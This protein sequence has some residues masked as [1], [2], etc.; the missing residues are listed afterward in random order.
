MFSKFFIERPRFAIVIALV[1][2][3]AGL[4][5]LKNLP[6]EKY[7]TITPPQVMVTATYPGAS[8]DVVE[9]T[10]AS[11]LETAV[12]GVENMIYMSSSSS[13]G[14]YRL[15]IYFQV[16]TDP[17][18]AVV[19]VQNKLSLATARLPDEV[20]RYG[21]TIKQSTQGSG[22][23]MYGLSSPDNSVD[24]LTVSNYAS[25]FIKD[26]LA[27]I[28]GVAEVNVFGARD[29]AIRIWL[30]AQKMASLNVSPSEVN[31]A[32]Q[33]QNAQVP[34]GE[35]G[36]EPMINKQDLKITLRTK[37]RLA[38]PEEFGNIVVKS[39]P[40]G[41]AIRVKDIA[42]VELDAESFSFAGRVNMEPMVVIQVVQL[43]NANAIDI[44]DKAN[45]RMEELSKTFPKGIEYKITRDETEF[46]SESLAEVGKAIV[47]AII[48]V[49]LTVY[50]FLGDWRASLIPFLAIPVSLIGTFNFFAAFGFSLNT[51]TLFGL[52][53]AVGT[54]VDDAIVVVE[55]V[56]RHIDEEGRKPKEATII[57]M[58]EVS[59]A[60]L[61]TSLV[62]MAVFVPV[63]FLSGIQGKMFQQFA[64]TIAVSIG[65]STLV[66]FT[67]AP[68]LCAIILRSK[69]E[70][71]ERTIFE[72]YTAFHHDYWES[73]NATTKRERF[74]ALG[75]YLACI[76]DVT[77]KKFN[78]SFEKLRDKYLMGS[79]YFIKRPSKT[80]WVYL[81]LIVAMLG[82][83]KLTP[84][85]FLPEED[86][87]ALMTNVILTDGSTISKT[88]ELSARIE[89]EVMKLKGVEYV[90]GLVGFSG[91]NTAI[92]ITVFKPWQERAKNIFTKPENDATLQGMQRR[93]GAI[94]AK[95]TD[96]R[97]QSFVPPSIPGL[98]M[99]GGLEYQLLDKGN[100]TPQE[101]G[102]E[103]NKFIS[104][105]QRDPTFANPG[106]FTQYNYNTPQMI[107]NIDYQKALAQGIPVSE[108]YTAL[109]AQF[110]QA[111]VND[112]NRYGRVFRVIMQAEEE[113]RSK[114]G[115]LDKI[116]VK[117]AS[118]KMSPLSSIVELEPITGPYSITRFNMYP[119]VQISALPAQGKSSGDAIKT[120]EEFSKSLPQD[121]GYAWSGTSLQEIEASGQIVV[122][123]GMILV[124]VYLFLVA[125]YESWMLPIGVM[126]I[127]PIAMLGAV[128]L[129]Y[130]T[131]GTVD[132]YV[133]IGFIMLI[134]LAAKQA[135]LIIEFAKIAREEQG[136]SVFEAA[137][138]AAKIRFRAVMMTSLAFILGILPLVFATGPG[139]ESR[140]SLGVTVFGGMVAAAI[141]GAILVPAFYTLVQDLREKYAWGKVKTAKSDKREENE[142]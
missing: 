98:S 51:L 43:A 56:Q 2:V 61:A 130:I 25:I 80:V 58:E 110:G 138:E 16:G 30:D 4:I 141:I 92:L 99:F 23:V 127:A 3:L 24:L 82:L 9:K 118:G 123:L 1:I 74:M 11:I 73:V 59:G 135:I 38:S 104:E 87:G 105:V 53:L 60:V 94:T 128:F 45:K 29:Y 93:I 39:Q 13:N 129:R 34:A 36:S 22:L 133:Q 101:L 134:G 76:W 78:K 32:I 40:N 124:F 47:L 35:I 20:K 8:A 46:I 75:E 31:A 44:A 10:V 83:F 64:V 126:L 132:L 21:L 68:A 62:L 33:A 142:K 103:A 27:R 63:A 12:N 66:A 18:I 139:S 106:V 102:F 37:G 67:L 28:K 49:V 137:M 125:L 65:F 140:R 26:E 48:L 85:G 131:G 109:G 17:N 90:I 41:Q 113:Y 79:E 14:S 121:M 84:Q 136:L 42:R 120:M 119:A 77:L 122:I 112:F 6:L 86:V 72:K 100:R 108:I 88:G 19:N 15:N 95:I 81:A 57:S 91:E 69:D 107:V 52:V 5:S 96:A 54:V 7:P 55:N 89:R 71:P 117:S 97:I 114:P 115:D 50:L 70:M 116:F 111:Y